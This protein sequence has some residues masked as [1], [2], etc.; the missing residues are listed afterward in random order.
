MGQCDCSQDS[1][2]FYVLHYTLKLPLN[3][4]D[5]S[6]IK[7]STHTELGAGDIHVFVLT[8]ISIYDCNNLSAYTYS[9]PTLRYDAIITILIRYSWSD[10]YLKFYKMVAKRQQWLVRK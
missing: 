8:R 10:F 5:I 6:F 3:I 2:I 4:T 7:F 1:E 9:Y